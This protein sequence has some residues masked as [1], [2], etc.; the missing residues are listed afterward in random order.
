MP[1]QTNA[2]LIAIVAM[3]A[4]LIVFRPMMLSFT[5]I[6][7][8]LLYSKCGCYPQPFPVAVSLPEIFELSNYG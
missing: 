5:I 8:F 4:S 2:I 6:F 7:Y 1:R 3:P